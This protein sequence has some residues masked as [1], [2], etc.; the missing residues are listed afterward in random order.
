MPESFAELT[1]DPR[2]APY[3][4]DAIP[5]WLW[6][7]DGSQILWSNA[8]GAA[9]FGEASP[10]ALRERRFDREHLASRDVA[11]LAEALA[12]GGAQDVE[13]RGF[14]AGIARATACRCSRVRV[15]REAA[16]L[17]VAA[18]ASEPEMPFEERVQRLFAGDQTS[19]VF[20]VEGGLLHAGATAE[21]WLSGHDSLGTL[22]AEELRLEALRNGWAGGGS[23]CGPLTLHRIG[24]GAA[25]VLAATFADLADAE[26][27][28]EL[29]PAE[30][31][32]AAAPLIDSDPL[33]TDVIE[34]SN[35]AAGVVAELTVP[36][37]TPGITPELAQAMPL[38][39]DL[40]LR[41]LDRKH[42]LRF[43]WQIDQDGRFTLDSDEFVALIGPRA[44]AA[45]GHPWNEMAAAL[46]LDPD[47][48]VLRALASH[49]TFSGV[50]VAWPAG[51]SSLRLPVA[52]SGLPILGSDRSFRGYRGFGVCRDV[53]QIAAVIADRRSRTAAEVHRATADARCRAAGRGLRP[54][55]VLGR[56]GAGTLRRTTAPPMCSRRR[57]RVRSSPSCPRSRTWCRSARPRA[58]PI[59]DAP[60]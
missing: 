35:A 16:V 17:V 14:G 29:R 5:V 53:D 46:G 41:L 1:R 38:P 60:P 3:A 47:G 37:A 42:P 45:L 15:G 10:K 59:T 44:A 8:A 23:V 25:T 57:S 6:A 13:L 22:Q 39:L 11:R 33:L 32:I 12:E 9:L 56:T 30:A 50:I 48:R 26:I 49:D 34:S 54:R 31:A 36:A 19:A 28:A 27:I 24:A 20:S 55:C 40:E 51:G 58:L 43:V 4:T 21:E 7:A 18:T 52:L 2:L